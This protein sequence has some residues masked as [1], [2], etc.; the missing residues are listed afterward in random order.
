MLYLTFIP[1]NIGIIGSTLNTHP[2]KGKG[3]C[4]HWP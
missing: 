1:M 3:N 2:D 4:L